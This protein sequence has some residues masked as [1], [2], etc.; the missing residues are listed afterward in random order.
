M[1]ILFL[2]GNQMTIE[3]L[4]YIMELILALGSAYGSCSALLHGN[5]SR[6]CITPLCLVSEVIK[7]NKCSLKGFDFWH[8]LKN[9]YWLWLWLCS[10]KFWLFGSG[11]GS[12]T[13]AS[14]TVALTLARWFRLLAKNDFIFISNGVDHRHFMYLKISELYF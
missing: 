14:G 9:L 1:N 12:K 2:E 13:L 11:S 7:E 3:K 10:S 5:A 8:R 6:N 4:E